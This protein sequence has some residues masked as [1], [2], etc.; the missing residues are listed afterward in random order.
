MHDPAKFDDPMEFKP[1]RY[2]GKDGKIDPTV[3][4][5]EAGAFGYGR[6]YATCLG[7]THSIESMT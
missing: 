5:P 4:S 3:L 6:R 2:L 7:Y 1:E